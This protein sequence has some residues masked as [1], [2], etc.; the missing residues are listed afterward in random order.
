M[1]ISTKHM[2]RKEL[3][4]EID[5]LHKKNPKMFLSWNEYIILE[6]ELNKK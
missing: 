4:Q 3:K 2:S 6:K 1:S 5:R